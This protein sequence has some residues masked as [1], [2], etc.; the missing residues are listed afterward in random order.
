MH[1][2]GQA[3]VDTFCRALFRIL[4]LSARAFPP[5]GVPPGTLNEDETAKR[6][7][8]SLPACLAIPGR[9]GG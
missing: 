1:A 5:A 2:R 4:Y 6:H 9:H 8:R 3:M 7:C